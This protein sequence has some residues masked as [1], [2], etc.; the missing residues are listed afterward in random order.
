MLIDP[1][2]F[3]SEGEKLAA[4]TKEKLNGKPLN[5]IFTTNHHPD[6]TWSAHHLLGVFPEARYYS[7]PQTYHNFVISTQDKVEFW[8]AV[9]GPGHFPDVPAVPE[10]FNHT[11]FVLPGDESSPI[12]LLS[13]LVGDAVDH[14]ILWLPK[15]RVVIAGD[16]VYGRKYPVLLSD[17]PTLDLAESWVNALKLIS[18]LEPALVIPGHSAPGETLDGHTDVKFTL[19]YVEWGIKNILAAAEQPTPKQIYDGLLSAFPDATRNASFLANVTAESLGK[20]GTIWEENIHEDLTLRK[21][22]VLD[23]Y[24]LSGKP[25]SASQQAVKH[26]EL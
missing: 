4:W 22:G 18:A 19:D 13:P 14:A 5:A 12:V 15:E 20:D 16:V 23:A 9:V 21:R 26:S 10:P 7:T 11:I 25:A 17:A 6:H 1:P 2:W 24:I 3:T 8:K